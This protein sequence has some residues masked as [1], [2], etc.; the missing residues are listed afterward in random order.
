MKLRIVTVNTSLIKN[1]TTFD[2]IIRVEKCP[3]LF[4]DELT[5]SKESA[6]LKDHSSKFSGVNQYETLHSNCQYITDEE[7]NNF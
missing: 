4:K 1:I 3:G 7:Y 6:N 5:R 2:V